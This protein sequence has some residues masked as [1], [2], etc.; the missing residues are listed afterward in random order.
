MVNYQSAREMVTA[1]FCHTYCHHK[2]EDQP[3]DY[4][5]WFSPLPKIHNLDQFACQCFSL[6]NIK[7]ITKN[8]KQPHKSSLM[9]KNL[10]HKVLVPFSLQAKHKIKI[11]VLE[12]CNF[13]NLPLRLISCSTMGRSFQVKSSMYSILRAEQIAHHYKPC[14]ISHQ[15]KLVRYPIAER[16]INSRV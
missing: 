14:L 13:I 15:I 4:N 10:L 12:G 5:P 16:R 1:P 2:N 8:K 11:E 7:P 3:K 9:E 6:V